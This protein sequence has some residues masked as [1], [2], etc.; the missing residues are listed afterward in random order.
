MLCKPLSYANY[1]NSNLDHRIKIQGGR[2]G[3]EGD[4]EKCDYPIQGRVQIVKL[5]HPP[6]LLDVDPIA[7]IGVS[8]VGIRR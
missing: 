3:W 4:L 1:E 5:S 8:I 7:Q 2:R 6:C